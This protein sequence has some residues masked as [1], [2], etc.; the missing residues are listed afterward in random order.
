M[1]GATFVFQRK[2]R[3]LVEAHSGIRKGCVSPW[4]KPQD[5]PFSSNEAVSKIETEELISAIHRKTV[6]KADQILE[7]IY[8]Y[9]NKHI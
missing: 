3:K 1:N 4:W 8:V 6:N 9:Q 7:K 5:Q 2:S